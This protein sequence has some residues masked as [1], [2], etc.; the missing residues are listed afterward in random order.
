MEKIKSFFNFNNIGKKIKSL[1]Q[2]S[3]W[4]SIILVWVG[5]AVL[6]LFFLAEE[7]YPEYFLIPI[8]IAAVYPFLIWIGSWMTY[9]FGELVDKVSDI[10][11]GNKPADNVVDDTPVVSK[12]Q[13]AKE[14]KRIADIEKLRAKGLITEEEYREAV[15]K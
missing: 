7:F 12:A 5:A 8:I 2:W 13:S 11:A 9:A 1:S 14:T 10:A 4:I 15:S 3:C 6:F